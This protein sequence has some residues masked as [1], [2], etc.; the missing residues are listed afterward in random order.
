MCVETD[1]G[2][3]VKVQVNEV[4]TLLKAIKNGG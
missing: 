4:N 1:E 2:A 3:K